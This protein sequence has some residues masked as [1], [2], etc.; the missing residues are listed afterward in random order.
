MT[1]QMTHKSDGGAGSAAAAAAATE[2]AEAAGPKET[3]DTALNGCDYLATV[4]RL[5]VVCG[6][7]YPST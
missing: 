7:N 1:E 3:L 6:R 5:L 2:A 4:M